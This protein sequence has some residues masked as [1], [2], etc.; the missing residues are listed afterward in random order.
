M[1][2]W[3]VY[4]RKR[5]LICSLIHS[6]LACGV[7]P[8]SVLALTCVEKIS[9]WGLLW[10]VSGGDTSKRRSLQFA[11]CCGWDRNDVLRKQARWPGKALPVGSFNICHEGGSLT[12]TDA[13][14]FKSTSF[15][16]PG[17]SRYWCIPSSQCAQNVCS[18]AAFMQNEDSQQ[19][20]SH[21]IN[22][23]FWKCNE[24][25]LRLY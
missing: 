13:V 6:A 23:K 16:F 21:G 14:S 19:S 17:F 24:V 5:T 11:V 10:E 3:I 12:N 25:N 1:L 22:V 8:L 9:S 15:R 18:N 20:R 7:P 2:P 4:L